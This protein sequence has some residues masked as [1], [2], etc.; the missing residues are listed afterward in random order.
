MKD[1]DFLRAFL[2]PPKPDRAGNEHQR[3]QPAKTAAPFA[4]RA[5]HLVFWSGAAR[6]AGI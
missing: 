1:Y 3:Y 2:F 6:H 4:A 5:G